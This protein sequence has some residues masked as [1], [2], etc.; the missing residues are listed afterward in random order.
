MLIPKVILSVI[1]L[2]NSNVMHL[3]SPMPAQCNEISSTTQKH[4]SLRFA[5]AN[6]VQNLLCNR[7]GNTMTYISE[8]ALNMNA[9]LR[10]VNAS[11]LDS[12]V[13]NNEFGDHYCYMPADV[14]DSGFLQ[15]I[16]SAGGTLTLTYF[17]KQTDVVVET[18]NCGFL[19]L[20][21]ML[22]RSANKDV[23][24]Y[25]LFNKSQNCEVNVVC[26]VEADKIKRSV[27][28]LVIN[29]NMLGTGSLINTTEEDLTP[30]VITSAHTIE[31]SSETSKYNY[32]LKSCI[33]YFNY[34]T[35]DCISDTNPTNLEIIN[36]GTLVAFAMYNDAAI[37][38]LSDTPSPNVNPYWTGWDASLQNPDDTDTY[39]CVHH[40]SGDAKKISIGQHIYVDDY[41]K[42][43]AMTTTNERFKVDVHY[44]LDTWINGA[45][46]GGSSGAGLWNKDYKLVGCLTGGFSDCKKP[47]DDYF[48]TLFHAWDCVSHNDK[49][50]IPNAYT[51]IGAILDPSNSGITYMT[52]R[53]LNSKESDIPK[54]SYSDELRYVQ[55]D[56]KIEILADNIS[57]VDIYSLAGQIVRSYSLPPDV[58]SFSIPTS[59][60]PSS[61]YIISIKYATLSKNKKIKVWVP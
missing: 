15:T 7:D 58:N 19:P 13:C 37:I 10:N 14:S 51:S 6:N 9:L 36:G 3:P 54:P 61:V 22:I 38:K 44:H 35:T 34:E 33:A 11:L 2:L 48:W 18:V 49:E 4:S 25:K 1:P 17:G 50:D 29:G 60:L 28:R 21:N 41:N 31:G 32:V 12:L 5:E 42:C 16:P 39:Y 26:N 57:Q 23:D 30:Y 27:C 55:S 52:G 40:P 43:K 8:G 53:N 45:T 20:N 47:N 56:A 59:T 46:E 24:P